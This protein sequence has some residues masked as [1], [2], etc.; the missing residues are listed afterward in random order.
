MNQLIWAL[1]NFKEGADTRHQLIPRDGEGHSEYKYSSKTASCEARAH[2]HLLEALGYTSSTVEEAHRK[3]ANAICPPHG[4]CLRLTTSRL[5]RSNIKE[6]PAG[7]TG[8]KLSLG[9]LLGSPCP[10]TVDSLSISFHLCLPLSIFT[11][12]SV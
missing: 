11:S 6:E 5:D 3:N 10:E 2:N 4:S 1:A 7:G 12:F 9:F 8:P